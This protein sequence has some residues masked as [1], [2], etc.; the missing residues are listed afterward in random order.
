MEID[1]ARI[2]RF[3]DIRAEAGRFRKEIAHNVVR[4]EDLKNTS[5]ELLLAY[6]ELLE[7]SV[8]L[9]EEMI[10]TK[11]EALSI[12]ELGC[13]AEKLN[14]SNPVSISYNEER[15]LIFKLT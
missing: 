8:V 13:K 4:A 10:V 12:F 14:G 9:K 6:Q 7:E 15:K 2:R 1:N 11:S 5:Y 3:E